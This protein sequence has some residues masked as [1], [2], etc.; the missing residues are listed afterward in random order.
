MRT[1]AVSTLVAVLSVAALIAQQP[2]ARSAAQEPQAVFESRVDFV[3]VHAIPTDGNEAFV[4]DL[5]ADDFE[6]LED[7]R[8]QKVEVF[9]LVDLPVERPVTPAFRSEPIEPDVRAAMRTFEGRIYVLVLDE[10][11]TA[12]SRSQLVKDAARKFIEQYFG[13]NDLGAVVYTSS[14]QEAGQE[15]TN[16]RRL[17]LAAI[18]R[19]QGRK[20]PPAGAEKLAVH[21][22]EVADANALAEETQP[23]RSNQGL[24]QARTV[25][26]PL[27][28]ERGAY[29]RRSL[30]AVRNVARWLA[31][32]QGRRKALLLFSEG[33]DYDIYEP[34]NRGDASAIVQDA[35]DAVA[36]AQRAN[37]NVYGIDPR[38]LAQYGELM[39][40]GA[41]S[42][43]PQLEYGT[44]RGFMRELLLAQESLISLS[45][46]TGGLAVVN[47]ND[48]AGGLARIVLDNSRYYVLG[49]H[50]DSSRWSR[51][52]L[53]IDVKVRRPGV[54]VRARR[55]FLPPDSRAAERGRELD[56]QAG[57]S[58]ALKA[59]LGKPVPV[60]NLPFRVFG[61]AFKG[62]G[63]NAS[64]L[65]ALEIDGSSLRFEERDGRF[66]EKLEISIVAADQAAKVQGGDRQ[67]FDLSLMPQTHERVSRTGVRLL[68][69]LEVPPGRYQFRVGAHESSGG[70]MAIVPYDL[71]VPDFAKLPLGLS[72]LLV[73]SSHADSYVTPNPD[74]QLKDVLASPPVAVRRFSRAETLT[75]FAEL[76]NSST[77]A[78]HTVTVVTSVLDARDGRPVFN[79]SDRRPA[80]AASRT[81]TDGFTATIPLKDVEPGAYIL[82]V[83]ATSSADQASVA[84]EVPFE[85]T[86]SS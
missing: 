43:Y 45:Q 5:T 69:R 19:F 62:T 84:R 18:D 30:E 46:E 80:D 79:T 68:S 60:G 13:A 85:V 54:R 61:A 44:N 40:V 12:F 26:D 29:A 28:Q 74:P 22:R 72:S 35:Q 10:L 50:S 64:V 2:P 33:I 83:E 7:G 66:H 17:L 70:A 11:Q 59:A 71:E 25:R 81:R 6:L 56:V 21:I 75:T 24:Q 76:Y 86:A 51:K 9:S 41:S 16:S 14:R 31:D 1:H 53:K 34:F 4:R 42:D 82:R 37:V 36:A 47:S 55:G 39:T 3:E 32:V 23:V 67:Q 48:V 15:L 58:P 65:L 73:T 52:F 57:T 38:G 49:Y 63:K 27:D 8:P 20:L 77:N 78:A